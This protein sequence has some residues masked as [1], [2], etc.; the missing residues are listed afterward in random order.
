[1]S[2]FWI[3][4]VIFMRNERVAEICTQ[5]EIP[6]SIEISREQMLHDAS[7]LLDTYSTDY[8]RMAE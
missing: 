5:P 3:R 8:N 7:N 1:M 2:V 6:P 4:M